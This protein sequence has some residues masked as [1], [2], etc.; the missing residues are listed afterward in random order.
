MRRFISVRSLLLGLPVVLAVTGGLWFWTMRPVSDSERKQIEPA[1]VSRNPPVA[2]GPRSSIAG[3][4]TGAIQQAESVVPASAAHQSSQPGLSAVTTPVVEFLDWLDR[5]RGASRPIEKS[6]LLAE[7]ERLAAQRRDFMFD[8]IQSDPEAALAA[9]VPM[10]MRD[11]LPESIQALIEERVSGRGFFGVQVADDFELNRREVRRE[12]VVNGQRYEAFVYGARENH[13]TRKSVP[14]RG[15]AVS[16]PN[17]QTGR[18]RLAVHAD[19]VRRLESGERAQQYAAG[20]VCPVSQRPTIAQVEPV[21]AEVPGAGVE[22]FCAPAHVAL[23]NERLAAD[24][25]GG[26]SGDD[27]IFKAA[28]SWSQGPKT[29]LFMRVTFP[30][31]PTEPITEDGA[32]ALMDGVNQ[33]FVENSYGTASIIPTVTP[34]LILPQP[35]NWYSVQGTGA[36]RNDA[37]DAARAVGLDSDNYDWDLIRHP[38]VPG[39]NWGGLASVR[40]RGLWLQSSSL[41]VAVHELGHNYGIW[42]ANFW[43]ASGDSVIGPG[44]HVEYGN[45]FD[46]MG[47]ASAGNNQFNAAFK[48]QLD[49]LPESFV[50]TVTESGTYR[51]HTFDVPGLVS[52]QKYAL[53]VRK[54]YDRNYWAEF[55]QKFTGNRWFLNG[56]HLNWDP[57]NNGVVN[58]GSGTHLLDT[59]PGTPDGKNDCPV[60]IGRTFSDWPAGVHFTPV[61]KGS[62]PANWIE[63]VVN[64]GVFPTN[65]A[66]VA[67]ITADR[68]NAATNVAVN[69]SATAG[70]ADGDVLAYWWEFGDGTFGPNSPNVTKSWSTNGEYTVRCVVSDMKGGIDSRHIVI[71]VGTP[72]TFRASGRI[73]TD[74]GAPIEGVRVHNG[75]SGAAYRGAYTDSDGYYALVNLPS[76]QTTLSAVKYGYVLSRAGWTSPVTLGPASA[77]GLNW[78]GVADPVVSVAAADPSASE[79]SLNT[80]QF[81]LSR[82]GGTNTA[83]TVKF[84]RTGSATFS[85]DYTMTPFPTN[86][87]LQV[88]FPAGTSFVNLTVTPVGDVLSEGPETVTLTLIEDSAYVLGPLAE[89][90]VT[91]ADDD[92]PA[93]PT[94]DVSASSPGALADNLATEGGNDTGVFTFTR[95]GGS[96]ASELVVFYSVTGSATPGA[97]YTALPGVVTIPAGESVTI[98]PFMAIDD[99]E[100]E[101]N[102]TVT[103]TI[104][105]NAAYNGAGDST[106]IIIADDDPTTVT[107]TATDD[108][109]REAGASPGVFTVTRQGSLAANLVVNYT[110]GGTALNTSDYST[111]SGSV[112]IPAGRA[113]ATI[114][115]TPV[116]DVLTE[117]EETAVA[118]LSASPVYNV[119]NPG[120]ATIVL[121]DDEA[122]SVTL[123]ASDASASEG[124]ANTGAFTFTRTG[125]TADALTV[126]FTIN[127][128][129]LNGVDYTAIGNSIQIPAGSAS[130]VLT[131]TP[132]DDLVF[133]ASERVTL[134]LAPHAA[135]SVGT[136]APQS[137]SIADNDGGLPAVGFTF[138]ASSGL[139]SDT[140]AQLSVSLSSNASST[141][142]VNYA[143]TG[144]SATG[145]GVD[146]TLASGSLRFLPTTNT[147]NFNFSIVNDTT[148]ETNE[149]IRVTLSSP[150]GAVLDANATHTYTIIDDDGSG[151]ITV[152]AADPIAT[153]S[154]PTIGVFRIARSGSTAAEQ[155]VYFQIIGTASSP[156]DYAPLASSAIIPAG[157]SFVDLMVTPVDDSTDETNETVVINLL[158]TPGGRIGSPDT[159]TVTI[160]DND[161]SS[162]LAVVTI[163]A[164]D[165]SASE[166]GT[167][168]GTF[169]LCRTGATTD[170]LAVRFSVG[171]TATSAADYLS[172]GT[173]ATIPAGASETT[174]TLVPRNDAIFESNETVVVTLTLTGAYLVGAEAAAT[175]ILS[176]DETGVSIAAS[177]SSAEDGSSLGAFVITRTGST[178]SNLTVNFSAGGTAGAGDFTPLSSPAVI[179]AGTNSVTLSVSPVD[180]AAPEGNETVVVTLGPGTG[181]TVTTPNSATVLILDD[182]PGVSI[183]ASDA[184]AYEAG[185]NGAFTV[186]R[187]GT[188]NTTLTVLYSVVGTAG[189]GTDYAALNGSLL[190]EAGQRS[191]GITVVPVNDVET[192]GNE[193]VQLTLQPDST[194]AVLAPSSALVTI[195]D[196]EINLIP[197]VVI[198]SP[199]AEAVYLANTTN[200]LVLE[201]SASDDGRPNPPATLATSWSKV[202][203]PGTVTFGDSNAVNTTV[204]FSA[205]GTYVLRLT[206]N[207][208]QLAASDDLTVVVSPD[209]ALAAGLQAYWK[210]DETA[211]TQAFDSAGNGRN[212]TLLGGARFASGQFGNA[213]ELDGVDDVASFTS[214]PLAQFTVTAWIRS[215]TQGDSTTPRVLAMPGYNIRI[216]RDTGSTSNT[217]ALEAMKS[218]TDGEWRSP[219]NVVSDGVWSHI[220][221]VYDSANAANAPV[222]YV[223]GQIQQTTVRTT[224]VGTQ[225]ANT[226]TGYIGNA[227]SLDRSWDGAIDE[228]R[229]YNRML[230]EGEVSQIAGGPPANVAPLVN[231][232]PDQSIAL[233]DFASLEGVITD[234]GKPS[235]PGAVMAEWS[236]ISG[237]GTVS[238]ADETAL[239]TTATFSEGGVY[240][241]RLTADDGEV[242]TADEVVITV[243]APTVVSIVATDALAAEAGGQG[244]AGT[245][246]S[247]GLFTISRTGSLGS[248]LPVHLTIGGTAINGVDYYQQTNVIT[249]LAGSASV[250]MYIFPIFDGLPEGEETVEVSV[251]PDAAYLIGTPAQATVVIQDAP[252]DAWRLEHFTTQELGNPAIS[253]ESADPDNDRLPNLLEYAFNFDP[254]SPND[255][256]GFTGAMENVGGVAGGQPAFVVRFPQRINSGDLIYEVQV[257]T[258]FVNWTSGP[259]VARELL[260]RVNN[261]DGVTATARVQIIGNLSQPG[262]KFVRLRLRLLQGL[263][264]SP[265]GR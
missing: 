22:P 4:E 126:Y 194:Y 26:G 235:T 115:V 208:G 242:L 59:T 253:G 5:Y 132:V 55:R 159:A 219:G 110:M 211:G 98:V 230:S 103:V 79:A 100:V 155:P 223:N 41:G 249:I 246:G 178:V 19:P 241:L 64:L 38:S 252:W 135:Y 174:L 217:V 37:R 224:A 104:L 222:F 163:E 244:T 8:L 188:T 47:A 42:H 78:T 9:A 34:L 12:V 28:D 186:T 264:S 77:N 228:L 145:G 207:D 197:T 160:I 184:S 82:V 148:V 111:L 93:R 144:G 89:A 171:G 251:V 257:T 6:A 120:V 233:A 133:E 122:P 68:L 259:N 33:W 105:A 63:V 231:A 51:I 210:F 254:R 192:E 23:L 198:T 52:G 86:S 117:G 182:E 134:T 108:T 128:T 193:T 229:I 139:E 129:A 121:V 176:D 200:L 173:S 164:T 50:Q 214:M 101:T 60:I 170:A 216:R 168:T 88:T 71:T 202:S 250:S 95:T 185:G 69:F 157:A 142:T 46:T 107:I 263:D 258:D 3:V 76:G 240:V 167:D 21:F 87:P 131:I 169:T 125:D 256:P 74:A 262:Q 247:F 261:P 225:D 53:K 141:V 206:A 85:T 238:F 245:Q 161:D 92:A 30:D 172:L 187:T 67:S 29:A 96:L 49:W 83:L 27:L 239:E 14:L 20:K 183:T 113:A 165:A 18:K 10:A 158:Q 137:V 72:A 40:G 61:A 58:S 90:T 151:A 66:P 2:S 112:T 94:V 119:G 25:N 116:N 130:T 123:T 45:S 153:E 152:V 11:E 232:G 48:N 84:N 91:I 201:A 43:N 138:A 196:D 62:S 221:V 39:F 179:P 220:A 109:A 199:A 237:P 99:L 136:T 212:A 17:S 166:P 54:N 190:I 265:V 162:S 7:G 13:P 143:V 243:I 106:T 36:L 205:N 57:W 189:N 255:Q 156:S 81:R 56:I 204:R 44:A 203:G 195:V 70:D 75:G 149:T 102:E 118:V 226:G 73:L 181:Y 35:K 175:V 65:S 209:S 124:G 97:D 213:L 191:A 260:P 146:Y 31:D 127:G 218:G 80:G 227:A 32:Y 147:Q 180:D 236:K 177:G 24:D 114:T 234:D 150:G 154:G 1:G 140:T 248:D 15:I 215:D 16:S